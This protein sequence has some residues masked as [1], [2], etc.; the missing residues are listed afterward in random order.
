MVDFQGWDMPVRYSQIPVEHQQVRESAGLFDLCHMGRLDFSGADAEDWVNRLITADLTAIPPGRA[1]YGF[2]CNPQGGVIDDLIV[3]RLEDRIFLV[4][5]AGNRERVVSWFEEQR[6][7]LDAQLVDRSEDLAMV[8]IQGPDA[9]EILTRVVKASET[10]I[11]ELPYYHITNAQLSLQN[12]T[13]APARIATTGYT[14]E[15]GFEVFLDVQ[16]A[17][18]LWETLQEAGG[19]A[20]TAVGLGARDTLRVE[21]GMPLYGHELSEEINPY[22]AGLGP[23]VKLGKKTSFI[24][25][26]S[27]RRIRDQGPARKLIGLRVDSKRIARQGMAI[28]QNDKVVGEVTSGIPS[29]TLGYP[30]AMALVDKSVEAPE[31]LEV[32][33]RGKRVPV[34][35]ESLPFYSSVRKKT[36]KVL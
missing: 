24:G 29:P 4:V 3:Y 22:E 16:L 34:I 9:A 36:A 28:L 33:V 26:E 17:E 2:L 5:N 20:V 21:A 31:N 6:K 32:D 35:P 18:D 1:R 30:I 13:T 12:A 23:V 10:P 19:D 25:D 11:A 8:A 15:P 27:L 7:E 14:G